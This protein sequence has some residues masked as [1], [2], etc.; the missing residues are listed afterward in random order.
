[1][2]HLIMFPVSNA[3]SIHATPHATSLLRKFT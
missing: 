2:V 3:K 1:M